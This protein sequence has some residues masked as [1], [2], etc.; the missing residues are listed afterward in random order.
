MKILTAAEM[1]E[2]DRLSTERYGVPSLTLMENAGKSVAQVIQSRLPGFAGRRII[3]LCGKGNNGGDGFVAARHLLKMGARPRVFLLAEPRE[4]KGDA[5]ANFRRWKKTSRELRVIRSAK[6]WQSSRAEV[7]SADIV[8]DALLG[9]GVRGPVEGLFEE[10]I[11]DVNSR[12]PEQIVVAVD[13][14]S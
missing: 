4:L 9:T 14:P 3:V 10:A 2:V 1:R 12:R 11:R 6:E 5:A 8:V 7:A 13:I